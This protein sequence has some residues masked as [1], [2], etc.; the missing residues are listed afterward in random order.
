[1]GLSA[2]QAR[3]LQLT[4]RRS[5]TEYQAQQIN[6]ER[7]QLAN[8]LSDISQNYQDK[9]TNRKL[10]YSFNNGEG[11]QQI[12]LTYNNYK[13]YM[14]QQGDGITTTQKKYFLVSSSGNK[15]VVSSK[16]DMEK[17]IE[18]NYS[19]QKVE[20][21]SQYD[22]NGVPIEGLKESTKKDEDGNDVTYYYKEFNKPSFEESDFLIVEDLDK[23]DNFQNAIKEGIYFFATW[24]KDENTQ[25]FKFDTQSWEGLGGGAIS[26]IVDTTDDA[27]AEAEYDNEK[28]KVQSLDKKLELELDRLETERNALQT[29]IDAVSKVLKDNVEKTFNTFN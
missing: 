1:M 10:T 2:S 12:D 21:D 24:E 11:T 16:E 13:N 28:T 8:K 7:L 15:I 9:T 29:E 18:A 20:Y 5:D 27:A 26:D 23:V 25:E 17:I 19:P 4:A 6:F 22:E 3:F 14:N